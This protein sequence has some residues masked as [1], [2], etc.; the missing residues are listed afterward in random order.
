MKERQN[1]Y[2]LIARNR[3]ATILF[4]TIFTLLLATVGY[5][6]GYFFRW[7]IE[8]YLFW[9]L[10]IIFYNIILYYNSDKLALAINRAQPAPVEEFYQLHNIVEEVA[11]AAGIPK[12][13]VYIIDDDAPNAF[14]TGRNPNNA[15]V[16]VTRG[17]LEMMNREELQGVIAHEVAHIRNYDILLMTVVAILGGLLILFRDIFLRWGFFMGGG[18]R[19]D[20]RSRGGG[21]LGLILFLV[22]IVLAILA[23]LLVALIRAAISRE[24][25]YLADASGAYIVRNPIGLAKALRKIGSYTKKLQTASDA[26]AHMWTANPFGRDRK[27]VASLFASHPPLI[28]RIR[29]LEQLTI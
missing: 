10:F 1:L 18:R 23:P 25:E 8:M 13:K 27:N 29:R 6:L 12:P 26:T 5:A 22:G 14:A 20:S 9:A 11:L 24:R 2:Q 17:L 21:Q 7:G 3:W 4:I 19:R 16:A 15:A 28:E